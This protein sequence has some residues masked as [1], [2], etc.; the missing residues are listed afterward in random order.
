MAQDIDRKLRLTAALLGAG[1][2]KELAAAFRRINPST[3]F[4]VERAHKWIQGRASPREHQVYDDW[5]RLLD[6]DRSGDWV[7]ECGFDGFLAA[8]GLRHAADV[9]QLS[10][11]AASW[12]VSTRAAEREIFIVGTYA[13]YSHAWSP[14][15][16][17]RLIRG[18]LTISA[19]PSRSLVATYEEILPTGLLRLTGPFTLG[20]RVVNLDLREPH[21][22][23]QFSFCLF[24]P[25]PPASILAGFMGGA[26]IIGPDA[27][28]SVTRI[29]IVR[30]PGPRGRATASDAYLPRDGSVSSD[31]EA[32]GLSVPNRDTV[33][34]CIAA[35][36]KASDD[37]GLDQIA[38]VVYRDLVAIFDRMW[39]EAMAPNTRSITPQG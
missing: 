6:L 22:D 15:Y 7:A 31:L 38:T 1:T 19:A 33:D 30:L 26:T 21:G 37:S 17:G 27:Q 12:G 34:R 28:P 25:S 4:D 24:P 11:R 32:M 2:V 16:R 8:V 13:C 9:D 39:L 36:L 23:A 35:F 3:P 5:V 29:V 10:Q 20:K 14:Y 18:F